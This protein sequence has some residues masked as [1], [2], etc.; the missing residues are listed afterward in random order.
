MYSNLN[1][2]LNKTARLLRYWVR[3]PP[4]AWIIVCFKCRVFS[5]RGLCDKL[6]T[7]PEEFYRMLC[8]VVCNLETSRMGAIYIYIYIYIYVCV[9]VCVCVCV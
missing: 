3:I 9:C 1:Y 6:I 8:G 2:F 5:G 4:R 7:R